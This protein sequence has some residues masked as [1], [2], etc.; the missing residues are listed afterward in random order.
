MARM[1]PMLADDDLDRMGEAQAL[2]MVEVGPVAKR[3]VHDKAYIKNIMGPFGSAK[4]GTCIQAIIMGT[5]WQRPDAQGER[6]ARVCI[7]RATYGQLQDTV[8]KDWFA[9]FP[10]TKDNWNGDRLEHTIRLE[11]PGVGGLNIQVLFRACEDR[12]KAEQVFK[13][14]QLTML[15][16]NEIDTQDPAVVEF[17]LPRL[18][19]YPPQSKGGCAWYGMISDMN[20]PDI[21]NWTYD[22]LVNGDMK[23]TPEQV[24][25]MRELLGE[26]FRIAFHRQPGGLAADAENLMNLPEGYYQRL[27]IGRTQNWINRFV[28]NKFGAVK[29]GQPVYPEY[30]DT[31]FLAPEPLKPIHGLP[32]SFA[33]D[34]GATPALVAGQRDEHG[35]LHV[36]DELVVFAAND[37]EDLERFSAESFGEMAAEWWLERYAR[38]AFGGGW[39]DPAAGDGDEYSNS[40]KTE[41]WKAFTKK[42]DERMGKGF[43]KRWRFRAAPVR[44]NRLP[45]RLKAVRDH[46]VVTRGR[47]MF[48]LSPTCR[49]LRRGFNNGYVL[50]RVQMS[51]GQGRWNDKPLKN[52]FSHAQD[53]LQYLALGLTKKG[54]EAED[55][56]GREDARASRERAGR[57]RVSHGGSIFAKTGGKR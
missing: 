56:A 45:E 40:W 8:M 50:T 36:L 41:F 3:F 57:S 22:L 25:Q 33:V 48:R 31:Y 5:L 37:N 44:G 11:V 12:K 23:M 10:Q 32:V 47:P 27:M 7:T 51:N 46:L 43:S 15:W 20:A 4:T 39:Y 55:D 6:W 28:H 26:D 13:G 42:I 1:M 17:G 38:N 34:G 14:M 49:H 52:D 9:W 35:T 24:E 30:D 29:N 2:T 19:R 18:G 53:G 16:P 54:A 21:D